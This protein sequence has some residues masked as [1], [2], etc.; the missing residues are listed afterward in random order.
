VVDVYSA[1]NNNG[2]AMTTDKN[3]VQRAGLSPGLKPDPTQMDPRDIK[4]LRAIMAAL[5]E[6]VGGCPWDLAQDFSTIAPYTIEEAYE[7][8]DAIA[9][10]DRRDLCEELGDL[11]LQPIY[12]AQMAAEEGSF[13]FDDVV[14]AV[15]RKM[16]RRHPHVFGDEKARSA[17]LA[18][19]FWEAN[20][21]KEKAAL[22]KAES[23][24]LLDSVPVALPGLTRAL[25]LQ[26]KA[27]KVGFDWPSTDE[28][29]AKLDEELNE[30]R[31]A[32]P[33]DREEELGDLLF[34]L[35]NLARHY[36][37][38]PEK[39][40]RG[41]NAKF[42]RRFAFI[43]DAL[44]ARDKKPSQSTLEEMDRLWNEAKKSGL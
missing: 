2:I 43:E 26:S 16:I 9:R 25:K 3:D 22:G 5:R 35:A 8:A 1:I 10:G 30:L 34:V 41:A 4:T 13:T 6:P 24:R 19:G 17:T 21:A 32:P 36:E 38:D 44:K 39:A 18:K 12:H 31:S 28:V 11:L 27:A 20:K 7:V 42:E 40:L 29:Y 23:E 33:A 37:I 15:C 14:E